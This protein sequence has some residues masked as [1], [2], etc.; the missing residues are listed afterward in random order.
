[1][2][3]MEDCKRKWGRANSLRKTMEWWE[4]QGKKAPRDVL[5]AREKRSQLFNARWK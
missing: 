5:E 1:M 3:E 4:E 2:G